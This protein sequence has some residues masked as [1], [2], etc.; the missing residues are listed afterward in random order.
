[1]TT[2]ITNVGAGRMS[3]SP[4]RLAVNINSAKHRM[5]ES[6]KYCFGTKDDALDG[7]ERLM[8]LDKVK[9]GC[10]ITPYLCDDCGN[11]HVFNRVIVPMSRNG[12]VRQ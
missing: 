5:C 11:W 9:P 3:S 6:Q 4:T 8:E 7:A 1:M 10:H 12:Q 2:R